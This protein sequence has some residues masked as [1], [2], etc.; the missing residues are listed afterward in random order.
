MFKIGDFS[1][2]SQVCQP[3][4]ITIAMSLAAPVTASVITARLLIAIG[5]AASTV[6]AS[7]TVMAW[8]EVGEPVQV[9]RFQING[10]SMACSRRSIEYSCR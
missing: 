1:R 3:F 7:G 4:A 5:P 10:W 9:M 2:L 6:T 8:P